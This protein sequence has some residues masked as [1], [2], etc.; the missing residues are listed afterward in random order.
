MEVRSDCMDFSMEDTASDTVSSTGT[1]GNHAAAQRSSRPK[2]NFEDQMQT[3][4]QQYRKVL[5]DGEVACASGGSSYNE[6]DPTVD[7]DLSTLMAPGRSGLQSLGESSWAVQLLNLCA[8]A[9]ESQNVSRTQ[10]LMWVLNDFASV[11]GD[12]NQRI[13]AYG[14]R[15]LFCRI[16]GSLEAA[17]TYLR[18]KHYDQEL[19]LGPKMVH[20]ALV[21]F[22]E[23]VPW[24]QN[25]YSIMSQTLLEVCAGKSRLHI[26]DIGAGKGIEWPIFIDALVSRSGGP[27]SI[28]RMTMIRDLQR[29]EH[30]LRSQLNSESSDFMT[31]LVK[32]PGLLGLHV[33]VN[34]VRKALECVTQEA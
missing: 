31:R 29:E 9:I 33:E 22:H 11:V 3:S 20:R 7:N 4:H 18:P 25:C 21:K 34:M 6:S 30:N 2:S 8:A 10:H 26:I 16:T 27:P 14:H 32:F 28:L 24:H 19:S 23:H 1:G 17:K 5:D 15:A 13:A 12:A